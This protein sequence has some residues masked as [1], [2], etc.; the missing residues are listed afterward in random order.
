MEAHSE[1]DR[2]YRAIFES[3]ADAILVLGRN[4]RIVEANPAACELLGYSYE[5]LVG[6]P[7]PDFVVE[8]I[9][10]PDTEWE[11]FLRTGSWMAEFDLRRQD[12][13]TVRVESRFRRVDLQSGPVAVSVTRDLTDRIRAEAAMRDV[14]RERARLEGVTLTGREVAHRLN[15]DL[16]VAVGNVELVLD[17]RDL[18]RPYRNLL[19]RA[20]GGLTNATINVRKFQ[21]VTRVQVRNTALGPALDLDRSLDPN[22]DGGQERQTG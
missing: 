3:V 17:D 15:N 5:E 18:P 6:R 7:M 11:R 9:G 22:A 13:T 2:L 19:S 10:Q 14:E 16:T 20:L 21:Q 8:G 12:G 4:W 1:A